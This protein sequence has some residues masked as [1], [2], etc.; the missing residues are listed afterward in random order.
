[1]V[2]SSLKSELFFDL[3][4][5]LGDDSNEEDILAKSIP[6]YLRK[7]NC[8]VACVLK[9]KSDGSFEDK[10]I[11]PHVFR[12]NAAWKEIRAEF[13]EMS[14]GTK[15]CAEVIYK[16]S[17]FYGFH[18]AT[19]GCLILGRKKRFEA[20]FQYELIPIVNFLGK[21]LVQIVESQLRHASEL[22]L[23]RERNLLRTIIN[24]IPINVYAKDL[25]LKKILANKTELEFLGVEKEE[26]VLGTTDEAWFSEEFA[27]IGLKDDIQVLSTGDP[28]L[29]EEKKISDSDGNVKDVIVSK[30]PLIDEENYILGL[31]GMTFDI[32]ER[33]QS[34]RQLQI[35]EEKYRNIISN[36]NIGLLEVD[37]QDR[38]IFCNHS[39]EE[40]SGYT[41][42]EIK[43]KKG[44]KILAAGKNRKLVERQNAQRLLGESDSYEVLVRNKR[45]EAR[46]WLVSGAPNYNDKGE[47]IGSVGINLDI[48]AQKRLE[49]QLENALEQA[50]AAAEA[51]E[52]FLANMSHE[53]RTPLNGIIGM[54]RELRKEALNP[55]QKQQV[56]SAYKATRHLLAIINNILDITKIE[57]GE[58]QL[59]ARHFALKS[60]LD[61]VNS[62]LK[63]DADKKQILLST[64]IDDQ[65][66]DVLIGDETRLRQILINLAGNSIK[67]T[68]KGKVSIACKTLKSNNKKQTI[69][70]S[71]QDTGI[72]MEEDFIQK[73]FHK[74]QQEDASTSRRFGGTGLGLF[75]TKE[76]VDLMGGNIQVKSIKGIGT[77][78]NITLSLPIGD[79]AHI[80]NKELLT[81]NLSLNK[82]KILLVEDNEMNCMVARNTLE[83]LDV[84]ISDVENGR[85][86]IE[87][88][89]QESF[90][91][92]LMDIQMP[93]MGGMEATKI[94]RNELKINT[95]IIA[96]SANAF[97]SEIEACKAIG[98]NDY[99]TKPFEEK[100]LIQT[101]LKFFKIKA[102]SLQYKPESEVLVEKEL[103]SLTKLREMSRGNEDFVEKML[104]LFVDIVPKSIAKIQIAHKAHDLDTI[105]QTTHKLKPSVNHL[106]ILSLQEPIRILEKLN[107]S[108]HTQ[109]ELNALV[110]TVIQTLQEVV[111]Q[112][113]T[114]EL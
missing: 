46:W 94:I 104:R 63:P 3:V 24:N 70:I 11:L 66:T 92:I 23:Q 81:D 98:M 101:V 59:E 18:L 58:L 102:E 51:K 32:T 41:L 54:V 91:L 55:K 105:S 26:D 20:I 21:T 19:Y 47:I 110:Q 77:E 69:Q 35:Q 61:D 96:L 57:A 68:E 79:A 49:I 82:A 13:I 87:L 114:N 86:A 40:M 44:S 22:Q 76:L 52:A 97:K 100:T 6:K 62:I 38:V 39:F 78:I 71:V 93:I 53:I 17:Y 56:N 106:N 48:T 37:T 80:E 5:N 27:A 12:K 74:F 75:I 65:L 95:P 25:E 83:L 45:G 8:F 84:V 1:M 72:G 90:D 36:I 50:Q 30:L 109:A 73:V 88:L 10:F 31:V 112:I 60:L 64:S 103:Y 16:D 34:E 108:Q 111:Q 85:Q 28:I 42:E 29:N 113:Q 14:A 107:H 7:L 99:I 33:K 15:K 43:G 2:S 4:Y 67:F 89:K 9:V